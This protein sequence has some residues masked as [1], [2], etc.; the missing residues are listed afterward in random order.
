MPNHKESQGGLGPLLALDNHY[1]ELA[2]RYSLL[3]KTIDRPTEELK[4]IINELI[5]TSQKAES[6]IENYM[7]SHGISREELDREIT[8][9]LPVLEQRYDKSE[10]LSHPTTIYHKYE[11]IRETLIALTMN[12]N[13]DWLQSEKQKFKAAEEYFQREPM[14]LYGSKIIYPSELAMPQRFARTIIGAQRELIGQPSVNCYEMS[15]LLSEFSMLGHSLDTFS[16]LGP[17]AL[18]VLQRLHTMTDDDCASHIYELL[19]GG[20]ALRKGMDLEMVERTD[21]DEGSKRSPDFRIHSLRWPSVIECKRRKYILEYEIKEAEHMR[22]VFLIASRTLRA[23]CRYV[24]VDFSFITEPFNVSETILC[25]SINDCCHLLTGEQRSAE[26][27]YPWGKIQVGS[28]NYYNDFETTFI[29]SP[30]FFQ[31]IFRVDPINGV[32]DGI[33]CQTEPLPSLSVTKAREPICLKWK[34]QS[35]DII[36]SRRRSVVA[37]L[38]K[39]M[40][41]IPDGEEGYIYISYQEGSREDIA[42][43]RT[44]RLI[45]DVKQWGHNWK[46]IPQLIN[47]NR[48]YASP[49]MHGYPDLVENAMP[50]RTSNTGKSILL[51]FPTLVFSRKE[52]APDIY[53]N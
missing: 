7:N 28:L 49:N 52:I 4:L 2:K 26:L 6:L 43:G 5:D 17:Y 32:W 14:V 24:S 3:V 10:I 40:K 35:E 19:V 8:K 37:L 33:V 22:R 34:I 12:I 39:A 27:S 29:Y 47:I 36:A 42:N 45:Q 21:S 15:V 11:I 30:L 16:N 31:K 25:Q 51:F 9:K 20:A 50:F 38:G 53:E 44:E 48:I 13:N 41:Q 23:D 18:K 46:I 1:K